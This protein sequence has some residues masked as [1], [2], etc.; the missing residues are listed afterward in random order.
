VK[1]SIA[2]IF[3]GGDRVGSAEHS[4]VM[5]SRLS[6]DEGGSGYSSEVQTALFPPVYFCNI[7]R[8]CKATPLTVVLPQR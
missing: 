2:R 5:S 1:S 6:A 4:S 7:L 3:Q 8:R